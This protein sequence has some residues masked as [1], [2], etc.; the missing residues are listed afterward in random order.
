MH[1]S[2]VTTSP[3][4]ESIVKLVTAFKSQHLELSLKYPDKWILCIINDENE[5]E[6][7]DSHTKQSGL[8]KM[9]LDRVSLEEY[10]SALQLSH[11]D[12]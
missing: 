4:Q 7:I 9:N 10:P 8:L 1:S 2:V 6:V 5:L 11:D 3:H 12:D